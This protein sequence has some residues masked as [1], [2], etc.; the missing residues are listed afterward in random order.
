MTAV[1]LYRDADLGYA[2]TLGLHSHVRN[3]RE[4]IAS[5]TARVP[6]PAPPKREQAPHPIPRRPPSIVHR[7]AQLAFDY[8]ESSRCL[9]LG[10]DLVVAEVVPAV[11]QTGG[12]VL[13]LEGVLERAKVE[14]LVLGLDVQDDPLRRLPPDPPR[15]HTV[16]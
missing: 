4:H 5:K 13:R 10:D 9:R 1:S 6:V 3:S 16:R 15:H 8:D 14:P 12:A 11:E 7:Y 2:M